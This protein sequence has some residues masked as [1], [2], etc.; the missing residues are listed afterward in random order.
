MGWYSRPCTA[1]PQCVHGLECW[2]IFSTYFMY[3]LKAHLS[4]EESLHLMRRSPVRSTLWCSRVTRLSTP[5]STN[6]ASCCWATWGSRNRPGK[7][8]L[9]SSTNCALCCWATW[10]ARNRPGGIRWRAHFQIQS[11][12][13]ITLLGYL[14]NKV[15]E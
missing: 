12:Q 7:V 8:C 13:C 9:N 5:S 11:D 4:L 1:A 10:G 3:N 6:S 15:Q 2:C 14:R